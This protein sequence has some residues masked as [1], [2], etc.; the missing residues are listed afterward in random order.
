M[1]VVLDI[2]LSTN[3]TPKCIFLTHSHTDH[4]DQIANIYK[5]GKIKSGKNKEGLVGIPLVMS[6]HCVPLIKR[7]LENVVDWSRGVHNF[8]Q[9]LEEE[10]NYDKSVKEGEDPSDAENRGIVW[11]IH[12]TH[13][14]IANP[15][16]VLNDIPGLN[17]IEVEVLSCFPSSNSEELDQ[18]WKF[19][20]NH[21]VPSQGYGFNTVSNKLKQEF[22]GL[23]GQEIGKLKKDSVEITEK[24]L[25]PEL[26]FFGDTN[27]KTLLENSGWKKYPVVIIKC[28]VFDDK[29]TTTCKNKTDLFYN[30]K[31]DDHIAWF[32]VESVLKDNPN[33]YFVFIHTSESVEDEFLTNFEKNKKVE[34]GLDNFSIWT[35]NEISE[36]KI[37]EV[38]Y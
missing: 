37:D 8:C 24:V 32:Q 34:M 14:Y 19:S 26:V 38:L 28:T 30:Q 27:A 4:P 20:S 21:S 3:K 22:Q 18:N 10:L 29:E 1:N 5:F 9:K 36:N 35:N 6:E 17:G 25:R 15:G 11:N 2:G 13:P 12:A 33:N 7:Q 23:K 16:M 31:L